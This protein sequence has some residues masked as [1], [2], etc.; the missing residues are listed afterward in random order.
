MY[1]CINNCKKNNYNK[2]CI[3]NLKELNEF[4]ISIVHLIII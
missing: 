2:I 4:M 1:K 3:N